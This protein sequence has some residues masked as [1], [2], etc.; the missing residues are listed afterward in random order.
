M[1]SI[2]SPPLVDTHCHL[3]AAAFDTDLPEV[4][5]TARALGVQRFVNIGTTLHDSRAGLRLA[6]S[7]SEVYATV[8]IHPNH[9]HI[10]PKNYLQ[11]LEEMARDPRVVAVGEIGLDYHWDRAPR[12]QQQKV[13]R[14]QLDL[15]ARIGL[16]VVIHCREAMPDVLRCLEAWVHSGAYQGTPLATR[17]YAGVLHAFSGNEENARKARA[18]DFLL[19]LG[20]PVT[21]KN[22]RALH[23]L[24]PRLELAS[25]ILE[26]DAPYLSPHPYRGTRN[27]PARI[28][29]ICHRIA[30]LMG[31]S[32]AAVA[33]QTTANTHRLFGWPP[34]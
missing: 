26:T 29:V 11:Q 19:G 5:A 30:E 2:A 34:L 15:A 16:P 18:L 31:I 23:A 14:A 7:R 21:F 20:G 32:A 4:L 8:G 3:A 10:Q 12:A 22:A 9:S 33:A 25:L 13:F 1:T 6:H 17:P 27:E 28:P 24:V